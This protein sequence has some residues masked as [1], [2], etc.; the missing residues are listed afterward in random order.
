MQVVTVIGLAFA[1]LVAVFAIQNS[2]PVTVTFLRWRLTDVSLALVI[3]GSAAAG[4]LV[5]ALLGAVREI[6]L[7]LS[8]RSLRGRAERLTHELET[9]RGKAANLED[10]VARLENE[11]RARTHE[12]ESARKRMEDLEVELEATQ[13]MEV[14]PPPQGGVDP[15]VGAEPDALAS[16]AADHVER[17]SG[18]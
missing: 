6:G 17:K 18:A 13:V 10:E 11:V 7:R 1:L 3:L 16:H 2:M 14:L 9:T 5:I 15:G 4:A 8:L 12:L